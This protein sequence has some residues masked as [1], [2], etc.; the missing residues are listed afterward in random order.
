MANCVDPDEMPH[1]VAYHMG[2]HFLLRP[3][4]PNTISMVHAG[5]SRQKGPLHVL[6]SIYFFRYSADKK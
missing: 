6:Y 3:V 1:S 5:R 4:C 2:L